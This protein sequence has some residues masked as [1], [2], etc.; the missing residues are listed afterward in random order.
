MARFRGSS[1]LQPSRH[2]SINKVT[3]RQG[4]QMTRNQ[5]NFPKKS[6]H[7]MSIGMTPSWSSAWKRVVAAAEAAVDTARILPHLS[8]KSQGIHHASAKSPS[9]HSRHYTYTPVNS[10]H[11][12]NVILSMWY[13]LHD[14]LAR[15][16]PATPRPPTVAIGRLAPPQLPH[17]GILACT[18]Q[19]LASRSAIRTDTHNG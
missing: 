1:E 2:A 12:T 6:H 8:W 19:S 13:T 11:A 10:Q 14:T 3:Q 7:G 15:R 17:T 18:G 5:P 16:Y 9:L 4:K